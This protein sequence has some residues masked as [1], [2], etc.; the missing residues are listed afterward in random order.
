[1]SPKRD[2]TIQYSFTL[3]STGFT[4]V[5]LLS[6]SGG[7]TEVRLLQLCDGGLDADE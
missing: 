7:D 4:H 5:R 3:S 2:T 1:L 6:I